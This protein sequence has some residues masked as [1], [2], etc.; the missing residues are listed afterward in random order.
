[1]KIQ[2]YKYYLYILRA[3]SNTQ[4]ETL[5]DR[6]DIRKHTVNKCQEQF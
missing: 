5:L 2:S 6:I 4:F 1:M 3:R